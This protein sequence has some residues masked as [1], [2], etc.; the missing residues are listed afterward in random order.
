MPA[1][2]LSPVCVFLC[3]VLHVYAANSIISI[4]LYV[5]GLVQR[6]ILSY[7]MPVSYANSSMSSFML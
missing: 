1:S 3:Q 2:Q 4:I 5:Y 7:Y 6:F